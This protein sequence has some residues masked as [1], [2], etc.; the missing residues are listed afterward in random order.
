VRD[1]SV[2]RCSQR[3]PPPSP[4]LNPD[5]CKFVSTIYPHA[6]QPQKGQ[7][8][9]LAARLGGLGGANIC[10][11]G[12]LGDVADAA[13]SFLVDLSRAMLRKQ[14]LRLQPPR[15]PAAQATEDMV[16]AGQG[17][18]PLSLAMISLRV[19]TVHC[20]QLGDESH[21]RGEAALAACLVHWLRKS[22]PEDSIFVATPRHIQR[23]A[24]REA[25]SSI[26]TARN[27]KNALTQA[28]TGPDVHDGGTSRVKVD[29]V[30]RLQGGFSKPLFARTIAHI[31]PRLRGCLRDL[32]LL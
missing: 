7:V 6:F 29:T 16:M 18:L 15:S 25:L 31:A 28:T 1:P 12:A 24:V 26:D 14:P 10:G 2:S 19:R 17:P 30:E 8:P 23:R 32:S 5:L 20:S 13:R 11:C 3:Q 4:R 21:V 27:D 9:H 22:C